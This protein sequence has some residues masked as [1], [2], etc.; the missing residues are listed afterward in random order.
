MVLKVG[1]T[2][3]EARDEA[4]ALRT[5]DGRGTVRLLDAVVEGETTAL[6]L[7]RAAPGT[8]LSVQPGTDQDVVLA[9]LLRRLWVEPGA[10]HPF[11][12]LSEM[13]DAWIDEARPGL[14][15]LD[16]GLVRDG[17]ALFATLPRERTAQVLLATDLHTGNVLA[18]RREPWLVIDPKP[19]V[20]DPAYDITQHLLND[21]A[22][23]IADARRFARLMA[24][25]AGV[26]AD[27]V[28]AWLFARCVVE[29]AW[30]P[31]DL[32]PVAR[33]LTGAAGSVAR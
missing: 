15:H 17:L 3:A 11:R 9:G 4:A 16:P 21:R 14:A 24:G 33:T 19:Y 29:A 18:A 26:D 28:I 13:C 12:P 27:R 22:R 32:V 2:H 25:L 23:L 6:L 1:W 31:Y 5:W 7:E 20:G 30:W 8:P 10:G